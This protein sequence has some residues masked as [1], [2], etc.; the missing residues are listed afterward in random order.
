MEKPKL[1][2]KLIL[3][4]AAW[5]LRVRKRVWPDWPLMELN[6]ESPLTGLVVIINAPPLN[7]AFGP[8]A[9]VLPL[10]VGLPANN[11]EV[12]A[13]KREVKESQK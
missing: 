2:L 13:V 12:E 1:L 8:E 7:V 5:E 10:E 4:T 9:S 11:R 6:K 3:D